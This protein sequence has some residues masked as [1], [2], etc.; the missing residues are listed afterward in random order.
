MLASLL[1]SFRLLTGNEDMDTSTDTAHMSML[2]FVKMYIYDIFVQPC[3]PDWD[4]IID[5]LPGESFY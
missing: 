3:L 4:H 5:R 2:I 1:E